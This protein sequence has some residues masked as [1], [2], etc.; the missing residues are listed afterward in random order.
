MGAN[1][2][3]TEI[4]GSRF[5]GANHLEGRVR[6]RLL[7]TSWCFGYRHGTL[8][9]GDDYFSSPTDPYGLLRHFMLVAVRDSG[10]DLFLT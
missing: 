7:P 1:R 2:F 5:A 9:S 6:Q 3:E 4:F 10:C 8:S